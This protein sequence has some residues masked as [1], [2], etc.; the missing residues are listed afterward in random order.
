MVTSRLWRAFVAA[1]MLIVAAREVSAQEPLAGP[2]DPVP[3]VKPTAVVQHLDFGIGL[4][5]GFDRLLASDTRPTPFTDLRFQDDTALSSVS[6]TLSYTRHSHDIDVGI[7]GGGNVRYFSVEP[8]LIP[9]DVFSAAS[10]S[11]KLTRRTRI[12]ASGLASYSPY[13]SFGSYM[14]PSGT[15]PALVPPPTEQNIGRLDTLTYNASAG[16]TW[17]PTRKSSVDFGYTGDLVDTE[18]LSYRSV[19]QGVNAQ[20]S[21]RTSR[22]WTLRL[23]YGYRT[24][25]FGA[26]QRRTQIHDILTGFGYQRPLSFSRHTVVGFNVGASVINEANGQTFFVIGEGSLVHQL[27]RRWSTIVYYR[28]DVNAFAGAL[29]V[30]VTDNVSGSLA[31]AFS[32]KLIFSAYGGYSNGRLANGITNGYQA[33]SGGS[34]LSYLASRHVP[35]FVEYVLYH[36]DFDRG[37]GLA[38]GFPLLTTRHGLRAGLSYNVPLV[39]RRTR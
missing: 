20:W 22:Y 32:R 4:Y 35:I 39:G 37:I 3:P 2:A 14:Q 31:G 15:T 17:S 36:Y 27:T 13:Y 30:F 16:L 21:Y 18:V 10:V 33:S 23:G 1:A 9:A 38:P 6:G 29:D 7:A 25:Q 8:D 26:L 5:Q 34:R 11:S 12:R 19:S 28:R 24:N